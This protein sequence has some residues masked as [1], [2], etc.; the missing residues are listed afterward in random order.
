[1]RRLI[2]TGLVLALSMSALACK[3]DGTITVREI[4]FEGVESIDVGRLKSA[5]A[6]RENAKVPIVGWELPWGRKNYFDRARFETDIKRIEAFYADR[7][8][9]DAR[10]TGVDVK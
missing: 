2:S 9:P 4:T 1:M 3:R 5:L 6:T 7:G 10:V 8:F